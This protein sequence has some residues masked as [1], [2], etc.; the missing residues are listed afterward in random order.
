MASNISSWLSCFKVHATGLPAFKKFINL[1]QFFPVMFVF[2]AP[3]RYYELWKRSIEEPV[4]FWNE[5]AEKAIGDIYWFRKWDK[6]FEWSY[7]SFGTSGD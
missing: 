7:P 5:H 2:K 1:K 3:E 4:D 6:T